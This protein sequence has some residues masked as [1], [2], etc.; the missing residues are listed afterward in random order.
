MHFCRGIFFALCLTTVAVGRQPNVVVI[1][2]DDQGWGDLSVS[3]NANLS[4]PHIDSL[5]R[6]GATLEHFYVCQVCAPTRAEFLTGRYYP[7]AG[8]SGV[9][10]GQ[11]RLNPDETTIADVFKTAGYATGAFGKW[12]NG[13][14]PPYHPNH[15]G[16][17]EYYGFTSGHW[18][19]YFS[20]PLDHNGEVVRGTG[21][22]VDDFTDYSALTFLKFDAAVKRSIGSYQGCS[23]RLK[24]AQ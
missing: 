17:D 21:F 12:H 9:S 6:D 16:F 24:V 5:A 7:R 10:R 20:P 15:R 4:T 23:A 18:G 19:H 22:V 2:T 1:L 11:G 13:T 3:G 14:Q 8:V